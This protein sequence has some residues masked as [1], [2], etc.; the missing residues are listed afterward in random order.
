MRCGK[1][2]FGRL[3]FRKTRLFPSG[4]SRIFL[5]RKVRKHGLKAWEI[6]ARSKPGG[7]G[8]SRFRGP[9][10]SEGGSPCRQERGSGWLWRAGGIS[11]PESRSA[12]DC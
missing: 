10:G 5:C 1:S 3:S 2:V 9:D 7:G 12:K 4:R 6:P 11:Y 8:A